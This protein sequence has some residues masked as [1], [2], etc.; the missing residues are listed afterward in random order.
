MTVL[1]CGFGVPPSEIDE[2]D[3][4]DLAF[5]IKRAEDWNEWQRKN[6]RSA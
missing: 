5:W 1:L 2:M 3:A 4:D 6:S